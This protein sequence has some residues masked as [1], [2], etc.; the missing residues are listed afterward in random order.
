MWNSDCLLFYLFR[1][2]LQLFILKGPGSF[3][4]RVRNDSSCPGGEG[5]R[6]GLQVHWAGG[7]GAW[8]SD[9]FCVAFWV[10]II[11]PIGDYHWL[12]SSMNWDDILLFIGDSHH[13]SSST[14][15]P[16]LNQAVFHGMH[17]RVPSLGWK[18]NL[19]PTENTCWPMLT[20]VWWCPSSWVI[21]PIARLYDTSI[22]IYSFILGFIKL[23]AKK[24]LYIYM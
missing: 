17:V 15:N 8:D 4:G 10:L 19:K 23:K 16:A 11:Y 24:K 18:S 7:R 2:L 3:P 12:S 14:G 6:S 20:Q 21:P 9:G 13:H 5:G 1:E 22:I